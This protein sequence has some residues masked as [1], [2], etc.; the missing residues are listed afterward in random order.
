MVDRFCINILPKIHHNV[1]SLILDS[2]SMGHILLAADYPNLIE[3]KLFNFNGKIVS[4]C[5]TDESSYRRILQRQITDLI[6]VFERDFND[7]SVKDYTTDVYG[8][9]LKF[10]ENLKHLSII[11][12]YIQYYPPLVLRNLP[13]TT[14]F[15]STLNKLCI[16][17][18]SFEDCLALLDDRLKKTNNLDC[19]YY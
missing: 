2:V 3:L 8:Y 1:K 16:R 17:V 11:G 13:L 10:F 18:R 6:I 9:I 4:R 7:I 5:F 12:S 15:S 14:F 19:L